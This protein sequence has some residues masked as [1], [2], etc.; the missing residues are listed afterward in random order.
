MWSFLSFPF[1][2][3]KYSF[4]YFL[5][6]TYTLNN[7]TKEPGPVYVF[8]H[9]ITLHYI[10]SS[11]SPVFGSKEPPCPRRSLDR[12]RTPQLGGSH[13]RIASHR[14]ASNRSHIARGDAGERGVAR[15]FRRLMVLKDSDVSFDDDDED[16]SIGPIP[17]A[18]VVGL[19]S[20]G[21]VC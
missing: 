16:C 19:D 1:L 4:S 10:T 17:S 14:I 5:L 9:Y 11:A 12:G 13:C 2:S 6:P 3:W 20:G 7:K 8:L 18:A 21:R 15:R